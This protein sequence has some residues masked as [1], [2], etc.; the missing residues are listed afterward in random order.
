MLYEDRVYG[1]VEID[2]TVLLDL[3]HSAAL[4][5][6]RGVYQHGI[7]GLLGITN[8]LSRFEHS[9]GAM[10][11]VRHLGA[12]EAEQIAALLHDVSHTAFSHVADHVFAG[13]ESYHEAVKAEYVAGT[14][15][16]DILA[17]HGHDWHAFLHEDAY[18]LL[19]QPAPALCADR[20]DYF[21]RDSLDLGL[22]TPEQV[23]G[24]VKRLV[25]QDG[26][27]MCDDLDT[28]RWM[29]DAYLAAEDASRSNYREAALYE[30]I[31]R[32]IQLALA[33]G[34][35]AP[36]DLWDTDRAVWDRLAAASDSELQALLGLVS[37]R[38]RF[39]QDAA[40]PDFWVSLKQ[41]T[42]DPDVVQGGVAQPLSALDPAFA[43]R[44]DAY[45]SAKAG[46]WPV[47]VIAAS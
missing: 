40:A 15:L 3:M 18:P 25:V 21:L 46:R 20:V 42:L 1:P 24:A 37:T 16:P 41:R 4:Q 5:R 30:L 47:R 8:P 7:T 45:L 39:E 17:R 32:A 19:E 43:A 27:I 36:A 34:V 33:R 12:S 31:A 2:A 28:A 14:D 35:L 6:L 11:L 13:P 10:L 29:A 44:R 38:T 23:R 9:V 22:G 26:R